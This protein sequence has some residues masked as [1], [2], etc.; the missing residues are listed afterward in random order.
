ML[1]CAGATQLVRACRRHPP[2]R[3]RWPLRLVA[4]VRICLASFGLVRGCS[5]LFTPDFGCPR[6][7]A[8]HPVTCCYHDQYFKIYT[9]LL[10]SF[11][12]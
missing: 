10:T 12:I 9:Y 5:W 1:T 3:A 2:T 6:L 11:C 7:L 4:L 8:P